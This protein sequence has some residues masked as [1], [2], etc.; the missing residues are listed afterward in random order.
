VADLFKGGKKA[1]KPTRRGG[2][3]RKRKLTQAELAVQFAQADELLERAALLGAEG[4]AVG[5]GREFFQFEDQ[6]MA[7]D[8]AV[9]AMLGEADR[10]I[11]S[12]RVLFDQIDRIGVEGALFQLAEGFERVASAASSMD[13]AVT[14]LGASTGFANAAAQAATMAQRVLEFGKVNEKTAGSYGELTS[15]IVTGAGQAAL[16]FVKGEKERAGISAAMETARA[17]AAFAMFASTLSP[18]Y[19][20]AGSMHLVNAGLFAAIAG[21]AGGGSRPQRAAAGGARNIPQ[22]GQMGPNQQP[23]AAQ[24]VVNMDGA[25]VAGA[26]RRK[27]ANDLG[28]LVQESMGAR[29]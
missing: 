12:Q 19:A 13:Q 14:Q 24:V 7:A 5:A 11:E 28:D 4:R 27:T 25:I 21:G 23:Q 18:N 1:K 17:G 6:R 10:V 16:G 2:G 15:A 29:R 3:A 9:E 26:N 8:L 20:V 22:F